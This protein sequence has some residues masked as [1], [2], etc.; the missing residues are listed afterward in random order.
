MQ[1]P[2][3]P[4]AQRSAAGGAAKHAEHSRC[5][6]RP[7]DRGFAEELVSNAAD[8]AIEFVAM[9]SREHGERRE[10]GVAVTLV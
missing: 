9:H 8:R 7:R 5:G 6:E 2:A 1:L 10:S 3:D 4:R